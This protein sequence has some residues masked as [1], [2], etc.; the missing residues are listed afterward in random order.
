MTT[1]IGGVAL[2]RRALRNIGLAPDHTIHSGELLYGAASGDNIQLA[3]LQQVHT[4]PIVAPDMLTGM[5]SFTPNISVFEPGD[6]DVGRFADAYDQTIVSRSSDMT[7]NT[8]GANWTDLR[9]MAEAFA[10]RLTSPSVA[11]ANHIPGATGNA[12]YAILNVGTSIPDA[13]IPDERFHVR[14]DLAVP[15]DMGQPFRLWRLMWEE[16]LSRMYVMPGSVLQSIQLDAALRREIRMSAQFVGSDVVDV[17]MDRDLDLNDGTVNEGSNV[18]ANYFDPG[19]PGMG[20]TSASIFDDRGGADRADLGVAT[21]RNG[22]GGAIAQSIRAVKP[23]FTAQTIQVFMDVLGGNTPVRI[24]SNL[25]NASITLNTGLMPSWRFGNLGFSTVVR[26]RRGI[27]ARLTFLNTLTGRRQFQQFLRPDRLVQKLWLVFY[28][29]SY[30]A[31]MILKANVRISGSGRLPG[32]DGQG[33][34]TT[35]LTYRSVGVGRAAVL[36]DPDVILSE[37]QSDFELIFDNLR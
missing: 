14:Q 1:P 31:R 20:G 10:L 5:L 36:T 37:G 33:A 26:A 8:D 30:A 3:M 25:V 34:N 11:M 28:D 12:E 16:G 4:L 17:S 18:L 7:F 24:E 9:A 19:Y 13:G 35:E 15:I 29:P 21:Y 23:R 32:D 22:V 6:E 2:G 27:Q